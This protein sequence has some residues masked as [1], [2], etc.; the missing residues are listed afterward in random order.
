MERKIFIICGPTAT[1][2]TQTGINLAQKIGGEIISADSRQVYRGMDIGT[3]KDIP[4]ASQFQIPDFPEP[5]QE[6]F[7]I[8]YYILDGIK[9]WLYDI[10]EPSFQFNV[11]DF[12]YCVN[13]VLENIYQRGKVPILVGGTGFYIKSLIDGI[14]TLGIPPNWELRKN[15]ESFSIPDLQEKLMQLSPKRF[16]QMNQSDRQNPRRLIRAIEIASSRKI[17]IFKSNFNFDPLFLGLI[18]PKEILYQRIKERI[19]KRIQEGILD[20]VKSL[21]KKYSW[22]N[23]AL[24]TTLA[25]KEWQPYLEGKCSFEETIQTW[26]KNEKDYARRQIIWFKKDPR[27][28]WFDITKISQLTIEK[29]AQNWYSKGDGK[30]T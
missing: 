15:L 1:G 13:L 24:G 6:P 14:N 8:G 12:L 27:I 28:H 25:Y 30:K 7:K 2:K 18:A 4:P 20:E 5:P 21:L 9:I 22:E 11:A 17:K 16:S 29:F 19:K 26:Q 3:G 10:V 23:S